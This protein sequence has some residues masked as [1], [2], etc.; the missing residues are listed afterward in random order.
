MTVVVACLGDSITAGSPLW[1]PDPAVRERIGGALDERSQW[2]W[3]AARRFPEVEFRNCGVYGERTDEIAARL[4]VAASGADVLVVQ[5]GINDVA[6]G[7]SIERAG[8]DLRA[9][10]RRGRDLGLRVALCDVLPWNGGWP[11]TAE[12]I[13]GLNELVHAVAVEEGVLLLPFHDTLTDGDRPGR[14]REEWTDDSD[15]PTVEGYR[16]LGE[17]AFRLP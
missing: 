2:E 17:R 6:Q 11:R 4:E 8:E 3:W 9:M 12:A 15:H 13:R 14:M 7:R 10:V 16:L 1:D 5:G